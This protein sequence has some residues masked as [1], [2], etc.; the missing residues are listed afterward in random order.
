MSERYTANV[1]MVCTRLKGKPVYEA[2]KSITSHQELVVFYITQGDDDDDLL[3]EI[4]PSLQRPN[5]ETIL[6]GLLDYNNGIHSNIVIAKRLYNILGNLYIALF[7]DTPLDLSMSLLH[8]EILPVSPISNSEDERKTSSISSESSGLGSELLSNTN[9]ADGD[10]EVDCDGVGE[11]RNQ[12]TKNIKRLGRGERCLLSCSV[13]D[14][15]FD[16]PSLL[17]RHMRTHTG[18]IPKKYLKGFKGTC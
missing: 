1:N 9:D 4:W 16:R 12:S 15:M 11:H 18:K 6:E 10:T 8:H 3:P 14:K 13:C 7:L 5:T 2:I 17:K